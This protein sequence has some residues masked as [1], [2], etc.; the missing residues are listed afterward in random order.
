MDSSGSSHTEKLSLFEPGNVI[1]SRYHVLQSIGRGG[2]GEVVLVADKALDNTEV[3][4]KLLYTHL[5]KDEIIF[6]RFRNEVIVSRNLSHPNIVRLY[7]FGNAGQGSYYI[8]MEYVRGC[9]LGDKIYN[10]RRSKL[11]FS[12][13]L[14][15]LYETCK[16]VSYAHKKNVVHRD[17]KPDNILLSDTGEV[18]IADFGL[19]RSVEIDKGFTQSGEAV[20]TPYYMA[21]EQ[22]RGEKAD[23]R[24]DIYSLGIIA[25][26][27]M[28]GARPF[29]HDNW[30]NLAAMH[31]Q[32]EMPDFATKENGIPFW[33]QD[34]VF[35]ATEKS[36]DDRYQFAE[37][38]GEEILSHMSEGERR[39]ARMPAV[40][41]LYGAKKKKPM[42][43]SKKQRVKKLLAFATSLLLIAGLF[44]GGLK[45]SSNFRDFVASA[46]LRIEAVVG[47]ELGFIKGLADTNLKMS[48]ESLFEN[49][50]L[51]DVR[52]V[53]LLVGA[54][55]SPDLKGPNDMS[56]LE[57]ALE[58]K[59]P[60]IVKL[61]LSLG[62]S[63]SS[64]GSDGLLPI[65]KALKFGDKNSVSALI[66]SGADLNARDE[67]GMTVLMYAA[68]AGDYISAQ[69]LLEKGALIGTTDQ[70]GM[71]ALMYGVKT[72]N[73]ALVKSLLS[74]K[75]NINHRN[76]F[77]E[78]AFEL[79]PE[80]AEEIKNAFRDA[81][82]KFRQTFSGVIV[83]KGSKSQAPSTTK[84]I[85]KGK[86][87]VIWK[88]TRDGMRI[89][90]VKVSLQN[91]G[92]VTAEKVR[93][94]AKFQGEKVGYPLSGPVNLSRKNT[95]E[96]SASL[97]V[98]VPNGTLPSVSF[99][100][101]NCR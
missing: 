31:L 70:D 64:V 58:N 79:I 23:N 54:G 11:D 46:T 94:V 57:F 83:S 82:S 88:A 73:I 18:K 47:L 25:Y 22:I 65:M 86:P 60:E 41:S 66:E 17:M 81:R 9:S 74:K 93:V 1:A 32:H 69:A 84:L 48:T 45:L 36:R 72:G 71:T 56:A 8:S 19:A 37:E 51:G 53:K 43:R 16:G 44:I 28:V 99:K 62:A 4:L 38:M 50:A 91:Y 76:N 61:L 2:M 30:V 5:V 68:K 34:M 97:N 21:P 40:F 92:E 42:R 77:G 27:I 95:A 3:A 63:N 96:Y 24:A 67:K 13:T 85:M 59:Q 10:D 87:D 39:V 26:E 89:T 101:D 14:R 15:I 33:Y 75:Q 98:L 90:S 49:I 35:R 78:S 55:L 52:A 7:D 80:G 6:A 20:G 29:V 100:C 12:E